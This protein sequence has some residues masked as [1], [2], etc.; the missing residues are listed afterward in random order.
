MISM[1]YVNGDRPVLLASDPYLLLERAIAQSNAEIEEAVSSFI[2]ISEY[3]TFESELMGELDE[4]KS[5]FMESKGKNI[6]EKIGNAIIEIFKKLGDLIK[7]VKQK[8]KDMR[9]K[10]KGAIE[11]IDIVCKDNPELKDKV[12]CAYNKGDLKVADIKT[13]KE[14]ESAIDEIFKLARQKDVDPKTLRGKFEALKKK[15][16]ESDKS[17]IVQGSKSLVYVVSAAGALYEFKKRVLDARKVADECDKRNAENHKNFIKAYE[18]LSKQENGRYVDPNALTKLQILHNVLAW[19]ANDTKNL[20]AAEDGKITKLE[21]GIFR[22]LA[23]HAKGSSQEYVSNLNRDTQVMNSKEEKARKAER[24]KNLQ[25]AAD[26]AYGS[27]KG[28]NKYD[29]KH[30]QTIRARVRQDAADK[31][32]GSAKGKHDFDGKHN[33]S[34]LGREEAKAAA[35]RRGQNSIPP[36]LDHIRDQA[37]AQQEGRNRVPQVYKSLDRI[38]DEAQAQQEGR[39]RVKKPTNNN[40]TP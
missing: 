18:D 7:S 36:N 17:A 1:A 8:F 11:K 30:M 29:N 4:E 9:F 27:A 21:R 40:P 31:A 12:I 15:A 39:N 23:D 33:Q 26:K 32:Y 13:M 19:D 34:I 20:V 35:Q 6:F 22:F 14:M 3:Y 16:K 28:K 25:D 37:E 38:R 2:N 10:T 24:K 5:L